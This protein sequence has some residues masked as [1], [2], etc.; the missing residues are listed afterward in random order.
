MKPMI[1][2]TGAFDR[3]FPLKINFFYLKAL[4]FCRKIVVSDIFYKDIKV[5]N[6]IYIY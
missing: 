6:I 2:L 3:T 5:F 1:G 4:R